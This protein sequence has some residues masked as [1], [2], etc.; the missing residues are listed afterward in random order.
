MFG[1]LTY[2]T[3][4]LVFTLPL[5]SFLWW[6]HYDRLRR[7]V[8]LISAATAL[9]LVYCVLVWPLGL[10]WE[11]WTYAEDKITGL[12]LFGTVVDDLVWWACI[13]FLFASFAVIS[14]A[15]EETG[16]P[17]IRGIWTGADPRRIRG[18]AIRR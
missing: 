7:H 18:P 9:S 11:C 8:L 14:A 13:T 1:K 15:I 2:L 3:Y 6:R 4:T 17:V 12:E 5:I 10:E 16:R